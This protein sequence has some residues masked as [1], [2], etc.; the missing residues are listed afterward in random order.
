MRIALGI[1]YHGSHF[2]GWQHQQGLRTVEQ[3][4]TEA[5]AYVANHPI[6]LFCAGRTDKGV[7]A[8]GQVVHFDT[9]SIRKPYSW[10]MGINSQL[11]KEITVQWAMPVSDEFHARFSATHRHYCYYLYVDRVR[12]AL[13][14]ENCTWHKYP[15]QLEAMQSAAQYLLGEHDFSSFRAA[16]CQANSPI[17]TMTNISLQQEDRLIRLDLSANAFLHHMV[18][19]IMG[20]LIEIGEGRQSAEWMKTVLQA[21]SRSAAGKTAP[22]EGLYLTAVDYPLEFGIPKRA[23]VDSFSGLLLH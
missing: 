7:H 13:L 22:P 2:F 17:R 5:V 21:K 4:L 9:E 16:E 14:R 8:V 23:F 3:A 19:N 6:K 18:R 10:I 1:E 15:L 12:P 20:T 11:P